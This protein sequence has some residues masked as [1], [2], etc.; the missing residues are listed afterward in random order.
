M[1]FD[2]SGGYFDKTV[3]AF[4]FTLGG[5]NMSRVRMLQKSCQCGKIFEVEDRYR[6]RDKKH[7]SPRCASKSHWDKPSA[8]ELASQKRKR[9]L[10]ENPEKHPWRDANKFKSEPCERFKKRLRDFGIEYVEE[11]Q[12]LADIGRHFSVDVAWP[13]LKI[14]IEING[15]QHYNRD[16]TLKKYYADRHKLIESHDWK[17]YEIHYS[18]C[19]D[20]DRMAAVIHELKSGRDLS[21]IPLEFTLKEKKKKKPSGKRGGQPMSEEKVSRYRAC[22]ENSDPTRYGWVVRASKLMNVS[23]TQVKRFVNKHMPEL[24]FYERSTRQ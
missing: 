19:Y 21:A 8:R 12:P 6:R 20:D 17:L 5:S 16:K 18:I 14:G 22:I 3:L 24:E 23:H 7:C 15:E 13:H 9:W 4:I 11:H 1:R 10:A 2:S